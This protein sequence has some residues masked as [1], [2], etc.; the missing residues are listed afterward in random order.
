MYAQIKKGP[1]I[2]S[3]LMYSLGLALGLIMIAMGFRIFQTV[4]I[5]NSGELLF[6]LVMLL[7]GMPIAMLCFI[8]A[9][10]NFHEAFRGKRYDI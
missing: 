8:G 5:G 1:L 6:D 3:G 10:A 2:F 9:W 4:L 7:G